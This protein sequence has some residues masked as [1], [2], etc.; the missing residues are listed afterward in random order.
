MPQRNSDIGGNMN[1]IKYLSAFAGALLI[2][3][4]AFA[5]TP[6]WPARTVR[7]IVP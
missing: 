1:K 2:A 4:P 3:Q 6:N 7:I 5:Q